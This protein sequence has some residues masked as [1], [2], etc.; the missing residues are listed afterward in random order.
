MADDDDRR[1]SLRTPINLIVRV[2]GTDEDGS[3]QWEDITTTAD[4]SCDGASLLVD[5]PLSVG[6]VLRL[7]VLPPL[8]KSLGPVH[9]EGPAPDVWAVVRNATERDGVR[10]VGVMF[11]DSPPEA[12]RAE[13]ES[14]RAEAEAAPNER[15]RDERFPLP[16]SFVVQQMDELGA[17]L[18]EGL[19][20]ADDIS[21]GG[22]QLATAAS[23][24][25]GDVILL[26]ETTGAFTGRAEVTHV[27]VDADGIRHL[28]VRFL[29]GR[30]PDPV[31]PSGR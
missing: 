7:Q 4:A 28:H 9:L 15:R 24:L 6:Q 14:P 22:A 5:H 20:V 1:E 17:I 31:V 13:A 11:V 3:R 12:A 8:P 25:K 23:L 29:D 2:Q 27:D 21:R 19:T 30:S 16:V 26:Q 10:R 18:K